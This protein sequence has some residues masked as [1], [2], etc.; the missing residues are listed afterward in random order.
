VTEAAFMEQIRQKLKQHKLKQQEK[1]VDM[2]VNI[3]W[4]NELWLWSG[5][6]H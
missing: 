2:D 4:Q 6:Q 1:Q 5:V 3:V